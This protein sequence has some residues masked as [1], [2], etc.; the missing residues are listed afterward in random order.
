MAVE[1]TTIVILQSEGQLILAAGSHLIGV[2]SGTVWICS[3]S[4]LMV[5][6]FYTRLFLPLDWLLRGDIQIYAYLHIQAQ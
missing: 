2:C 4:V 1:A 6:F 5:C 3:M